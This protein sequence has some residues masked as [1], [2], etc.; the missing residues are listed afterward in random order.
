MNPELQE[1]EAA[2]HTS[3]A[4]GRA[5]EL[6]YLPRLDIV[7]ALWVRGSGLTSGPV[8]PSP[9]RGIVPDTPNWAVGLLLTWPAVEPSRGASTTRAQ[10]AR[11]RGAAAWR[12]DI[13]QAIEAQIDGAHATLAGA[14]RIAENTPVALVAA[15]DAEAQASARYKAGLASIDLERMIKTCGMGQHCVGVAVSV[16]VVAPGAV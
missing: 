5:I 1:A 3:A 13:A 14:Q 9:G 16:A 10:S 7:G 12:D 8:A 15:R 4:Q 11:V 2:L 6:Q